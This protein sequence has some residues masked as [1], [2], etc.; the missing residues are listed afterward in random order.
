[1]GR[2]LL[3]IEALVDHAPGN[4]VNHTHFQNSNRMY[5]DVYNRQRFWS[6]TFEKKLGKNDSYLLVQG[7]IP[8]R[9]IINYPN[10]GMYVN[11]RTGSQNSAIAG[12]S[13]GLS[14]ENDWGY[15][16]IN[17]SG[18]PG[19]QDR[20]TAIFLIDKMFVSSDAVKGRAF[21]LPRYVTPS[22]MGAGTKYL[23]IGHVASSGVR[24]CAT[25]NVNNTDDPR[26]HQSGSRLSILEF[27]L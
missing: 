1:M 22:Q 10:I 15:G 25:L 2:E 11:I 24:P 26:Q 17:F 23:E 7:L 12:S 9:G 4:L 18:S 20:E 5:L 19:N 14:S 3:N 27:A 8:G 6:V 21:D 13:Y 16:G